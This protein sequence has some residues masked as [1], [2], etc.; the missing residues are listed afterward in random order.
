MVESRK[1]MADP[2]QHL[3]LIDSGSSAQIIERDLVCRL[4]V[5]TFL[6]QIG[7]LV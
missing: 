1:S 2:L 5:P 7:A 6:F 3:I 4:Y